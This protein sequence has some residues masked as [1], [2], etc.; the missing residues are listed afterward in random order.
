MMLEGAGF[1]VIDI[2]INN[3]V[4]KYFDALNIS[5]LMREGQATG[6]PLGPMAYALQQHLAPRVLQANGFSSTPTKVNQS[7]SAGCKFSVPFTRAYGLGE[8]RGLCEN[9]GSEH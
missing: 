2:G 6:F 1:E 8:F 3:D 9:D 7:I 5:V 4:E